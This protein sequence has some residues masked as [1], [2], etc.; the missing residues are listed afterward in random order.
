TLGMAISAACLAMTIGTA[1]AAGL[2][3]FS[4]GQ[5]ADADAVNHNFTFL[6]D[7]IDNISLT[8]GPQGPQGP[9]GLAGTNGTDGAMGMQ[10]PTGPQ[11]PAGANGQDGA[12][13]PQ[14][15]MGATGMTGPVGPAGPTGP[16]GPAG[17]NGTGVTFQSWAGFGAGVK[18]S[19]KVFDV[20]HSTGATGWDKE[21]Q[22]LVRTP[23]TATTGT[24]S[25]TRQRTL[26]GSV[27]RHQVL[28]YTYD[29]AGDLTFDQ[30]DTYETDTT[31]L[32]NTRTIS[33][34]FVLLNNAMGLGMNWATA[35][36][37]STVDVIG[38]GASNRVSYGVDSRS[39]L[40]IEDITVKGVTYTGCLKIL[41]HRT[42]QD[43]GGDRQ[44]ISWH[45]PND[46]M[47]KYV[48]SRDTG[49]RIVEFD[50]TVSTLN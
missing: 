29:T 49:S 30:L 27:V 3:T 33:P 18:W 36:T 23:A 7:R 34:G 10:G 50:P 6:N 47:V 15:P 41:R 1:Q 24:L 19:V 26:A 8:P 38:G 5:V 9:Q 35:S 14:G 32:N 11:G 20:V 43:M 21:T 44:I 37:I 16:Q 42:A 22:T 28:T 25:I 46:G 48:F 2:N 40:A 31:T 45:C 17:A 39:L 13:G 12:T 4:N